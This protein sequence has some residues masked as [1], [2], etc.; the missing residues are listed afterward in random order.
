MLVPNIYAQQNIDYLLSE[1]NK[2]LNDPN[3]PD[4]VKY[5]FRVLSESDAAFVGIKKTST[6]GKHGS[7]LGQ[8][9][10]GETDPKQ[11]DMF[12][13][14]DAGKGT[15]DYSIIYHD[16]SNEANNSMSSIKR[17]GIVG[18]G[19]AIDYVFARIFARQVYNN[20]G[21]IGFSNTDV[22]VD[23]NQ[24]VNH[25]M[26]LIQMLPPVDQDRI[27]LVVEMM[28]KNY[29]KGQTVK[30]FSCFDTEEA[31][32]IISNLIKGN[33]DYTTAIG[34]TDGW[35]DVS[36]WK[37]D[38]I[39]FEKTNDNDE[40]EIDWVCKAIA[41]AVAYDVFEDT[42]ET[43][44]KK[45]DYIIFTGRSF[46][47]EPLRKAFEEKVRPYR[48]VFSDN[49]ENPLFVV[50]LMNRFAKQKK[51]LMN[52]KVADLKG[53][54]MKAISVRFD[55]HDLGVNCNS[56]LC[57]VS[58]LNVVGDD[59]LSTVEKNCFWEG[60]DCTIDDK[61]RY[62]I[63]HPKRAFAPPLP[64][65]ERLER[66]PIEKTYDLVMMTM[67]PVR[68]VRVQ[69]Y[70]MDLD[71]VGRQGN[72][73]NTG[74]ASQN[75]QNRPANPEE[76]TSQVNIPAPGSNSISTDSAI[77]NQTIVIDNNDRLDSNDL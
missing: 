63:G 74:A 7:V 45:I 3:N 11:K 1:L 33:A 37:W 60:F 70:G 30:A 32:T 52:L 50:K 61:K 46:H 71:G 15:T 12:L 41:S 4:S 21:K 40:K 27:M 5:D 44:T 56:D 22:K 49:F 59:G 76:Q 28:K 29:K 51:D 23:E 58:L 16:T 6:A 24:F 17:G 36:K 43:V 13:I 14:I 20:I 34:Q 39:A 2:E 73:G 67:F 77:P 38:G 68:Y 31:K 35:N 47:F 75:S 18:A 64:Q 53:V 9:V 19:G 8:I 10:N 25:F 62:Y 55:K 72:V 69:F 26:T 54:D 57:C 48:N 66:T 65:Q 42:E